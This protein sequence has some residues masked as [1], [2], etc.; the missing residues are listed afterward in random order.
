MASEAGVRVTAPVYKPAIGAL[1]EAYAAAGF[2]RID[3]SSGRGSV[4]L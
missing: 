2:P 4:S 3:R 1:L